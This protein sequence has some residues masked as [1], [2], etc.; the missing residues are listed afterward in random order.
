[1]IF[2]L[3]VVLAILRFCA[4][5]ISIVAFDDDKCAGNHVGP[6]IH[7]NPGA[8]HE[9]SSCQANG[10]YS[11]VNVLSLDAGFRCNLYADDQCQSFL[12]TAQQAG[13]MPIIAKG[14]LCF[15]QAS[16]DDPL[17][18]TTG[19]LGLGASTIIA[20][21]P[22]IANSVDQLVNKVCGNGFCDTTTKDTIDFNHA[23][24][25]ETGLVNTDGNP[26]LTV[27]NK[28][29]KCTQTMTIDG[30]FSNNSQRDYMKEALKTAMKQGTGVRALGDGSGDD[31]NVQLSFA[32]VQVN[33]AKG[34]NLAVVRSYS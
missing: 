14:I 31:L 34:S 11:S 1:M 25:C 13:C 21:V 17:A 12:A 6:N 24:D 7:S 30:H 26:T 15:S 5:D 23:I 29:E 19:I 2:S 22:D 9:S 10:A 27:C 32:G 18:G 8:V 28:H 20:K 16:F 3:I 4:C 33:D